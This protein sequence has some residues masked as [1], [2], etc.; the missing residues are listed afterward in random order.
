M[1]RTRYVQAEMDERTAELYSEQ[2]DADITEL[3]DMDEM[4]TCDS[5]KEHNAKGKSFCACGSILPGPQ[6]G[7][8][9]SLKETTKQLMI[10]GN[11]LQ[12]RKGRTRGEVGTLTPESQDYHF[13][14][15][16]E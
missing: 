14:L 12:L 4:T 7:T 2:G 6:T 13:F 8:Q 15:T 5:Y 1:Q 10:R 9:G 3:V 11:S 16:M